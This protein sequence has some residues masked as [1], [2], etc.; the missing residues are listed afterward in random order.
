MKS[1]PGSAG[2]PKIVDLDLEFNLKL[3]KSEPGP[4]EAPNM[5]DFEFRL[6]M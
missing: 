3:L 5:V 4:A 1:W 6:T 2:A